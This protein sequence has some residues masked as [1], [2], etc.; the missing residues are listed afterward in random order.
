[1]HNAHIEDLLLRF[2]DAWKSAFTKFQQSTQKKYQRER[3]P[4]S[5]LLS[6]L[7]TMEPIVLGYFL[8]RT[9]IC[10][11]FSHEFCNGVARYEPIINDKFMISDFKVYCSERMAMHMFGKYLLKLNNC[12]IE[13]E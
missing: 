8:N 9:S 5:E 7:P 2:K 10:V 1:L 11:P 6:I 13:I 3:S 12:H 4:N